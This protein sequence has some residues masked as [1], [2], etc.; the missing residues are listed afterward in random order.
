M[1]HKATDVGEI[2]QG[3]NVLG[4]MRNQAFSDAVVGRRGGAREIRGKAQEEAGSR[5]R[6][7]SSVHCLC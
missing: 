2:T 3:K 7:I 5:R 4:K 1:S 6:T